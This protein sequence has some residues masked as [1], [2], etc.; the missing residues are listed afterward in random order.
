MAGSNDS[1]DV[2]SATRASGLEKT[3]LPPRAKLPP[4]LQKMMDDRVDDESLYDELWGGT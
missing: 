4:N 3:E 2:A 1:N